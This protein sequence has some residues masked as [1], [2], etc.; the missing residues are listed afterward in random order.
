MRAPHDTSHPSPPKC[1][2]NAEE[3]LKLVEKWLA[4]EDGYDA[5]T[6]AVI[7]QDIE[8]NRLSSRHRL[9]G[10]IS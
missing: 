2:G 4:E 1:R 9:R 6:W 7:A 10:K 3:L 8:D 5:D